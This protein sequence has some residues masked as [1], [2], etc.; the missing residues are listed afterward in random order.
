VFVARNGRAERRAV[1][2]GHVGGGAAEVLAG[3]EAGEEIVT[4]PSDR[5]VTGARIATSARSGVP[6]P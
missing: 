6:S 2:L 3:L 5:V 4:F 1:R